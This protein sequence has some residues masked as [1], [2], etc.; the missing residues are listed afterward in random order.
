MRTTGAAVLASL[1]LLMVTPQSDAQCASKVGEWAYGPTYAVAG[2]GDIAVY[3]SGRMLI[4]ADIS[5]LSQP[6]VVGSLT[7]ESPIQGITITGTT[8][9][10]AGDDAGFL[11]IDLSDSSHPELIGAYANL[12]RV[13]DLVLVGQMA[14]V[15]NQ[16][17]GLLILD[18][19]EPTDPTEIATL[20][21]DDS[22]TDVAVHGDVAYLAND[23]D[24]LR[25]VD[26]SDPTAPFVV[27]TFGDI[28][29]A[30]RL[31]VSADGGLVAIT[32]RY[33][34][35]FR[36]FDVTDPASPEQ[37]AFVDNYDYALD[38]ALDGHFAYLA[39]RTNG[40]RIYDISDASSPTEVRSVNGDGQTE[41]VSVHEG[42]AYLAN[43]YA[44]LSLVDIAVP[45]EAHELG[46]I[47]AFSELRRAD[48]DGGL[49][50]AAAGGQL[51]TFDVSDPTAP[52]AFGAFHPYGYAN[53]VL[54]DGD[55]A[56]VASDYGGLHVIDVSDPSEPV[57]VG[58]AETCDAYRLTKSGDIVYVG[59]YDDGLRIVDVSS[60]TEP[61]E[62]GRL[63]DFRAIDV[64]VVDDILYACDYETGLYII[65]VSDPTSPTHVSVLDVPTPSHLPKVN[66]DLL[67]VATS[68]NGVFIYD[69]TNPRVPVEVG[70]APARSYL[71]GTAPVGEILFVASIYN[72]AYVYDVSD[73]ASPVELATLDFA[74][75]REG[76]VTQEGSLVMATETNGGF[77]IFDLNSC[78]NE[79]PTASFTWRPSAPEAG[80]S[81]QLTDTS[82]GAIATWTW[83]FGDDGASTER[84][85]AHVWS[86]AGAYNVT[87]TVSGPLGSRSITRIVTVYPRSGDVPPITDPGDHAY[88]IAAAAHAPGLA[89]TQ[90]VTDVVL[91]NPDTVGAQAF[92]WFMKA[93]QN[94]VGAEGVGIPIAAG[95]SVAVDDIV[96]TLFSE[97]N[98]AGAVLVG[99]DQTLV[100]TSRTYND[101]STGTYGQFIP[102]RE[103]DEAVAGDDTAT[104]IELTRS[105]DFRTNLGVA[106]PTPSTVNVDVTLRRANGSQIATRS[107]TVPPFGY[108][109][110]TDILGTDVGDAFAVISSKTAGAAYF[111]Y[112]SVV[113]NRTGDPIMI[114]PIEA[115]D[116]Q[117][118]AAAAH[119]GGLVGTDWRTDLEVCNP[120]ATGVE[121]D[122]RL[123][124]SEHNNSNPASV[125]LSVPSGGCH[126][127]ADVLMT[128]FSHEGT[129]ALEVVAS[130]GGII[131]SSRTFNTTDDGTFGQFLRGTPSSDVISSGQSARL[132]QLTQDVNDTTGFRTNL[133]FVNRS[134]VATTIN[135]AMWSSSGT[136]LG[137]LTVHLAPFEHRQINRV[138]RQVTSTAIVNGTVTVSTS[139]SGGG[140]V[141]YASVVD[142]VS[143]DP[144][145]IPATIVGN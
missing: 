10:V 105:S 94:N 113:D 136:H 137:D 44:G 99:C 92:L 18:I 129:G 46:S 38:I 118:V 120:L 97:D 49:A 5:D 34:G 54:I 41:G 96:A 107:L 50:M 127:V 115:A 117:V 53:S 112:A 47:E 28:G 43:H 71:F 130:S 31:A 70:N 85:P 20:D 15:A 40:L 55:L 13:A 141:A 14:Y 116:L 61:R 56:Y 134:S 1:A 7:L 29:R 132:T 101:A 102:G 17:S 24:G 91:H 6:E 25:V 133:G 142:N 2:D 90:W 110:R 63:E 57:V 87:L 64:V 42:I 140:F 138:F 145:F 139:S 74:L 27:S 69:I 77:E 45:A 109:Q 23:D 35:V 128:S 62:I 124:E 12:D 66:G 65:D 59:C 21:F 95:T 121:V 83:D 58:T 93:D 30:Q 72:G 73:P 4:V 84:F 11:V 76:E 100:V 26:V 89:S 33:E 19:S 98:A 48:M 79:A 52:T 126:R 86:E 108:L 144:V 8:A 114:E 80:R 51:I 106:N 82:F 135:V 78:F 119:V 9:F 143:G 88:I 122:V 16:G 125:P 103:L 36:L 67:F 3:G 22:V 37:V 68:R 131:A 123:L 81:V 32:D 111:P 60:S 104:L 75:N 39:N